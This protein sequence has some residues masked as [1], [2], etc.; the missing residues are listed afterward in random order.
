MFEQLSLFETEEERYN[1]I[2]KEIERIE[3]EREDISNKISNTFQLSIPFEG[4]NYEDD[5]DII[6][7]ESD[8]AK[9]KIAKR[10]V[11]DKIK[12]EISFLQDLESSVSSLINDD[13]NESMLYQLKSSIENIKKDIDRAKNSMEYIEST[14][15]VSSESFHK[16][17][18][19]TDYLQEEDLDSFVYGSDAVAILNDIA[20][21]LSSSDTNVDKVFLDL[22]DPN[23][24]KSWTVALTCALKGHWN[25]KDCTEIIFDASKNIE[26][27][28]K[29]IYKRYLEFMDRIL[30]Y[31]EGKL[32][33]NLSKNNSRIEYLSELK[34]AKEEYKK[35][36][37][38]L[39]SYI[40]Y[41][42][43][44]LRKIQAIVTSGAYF[45]NKSNSLDGDYSRNAFLDIGEYIYSYKITDSVGVIS[46][47]LIS[48]N[49]YFK[50]LLSTIEK[51]GENYIQT[52]SEAVLYG[53]S[54]L[55][56]PLLVEFPNRFGNEKFSKAINNIKNL[57]NVSYLNRG[58][59][60]RDEN[61][62]F[63]NAQ[64]SS[65]DS[66]IISIGRNPFD[67][68]SFYYDESPY[69][70]LARWDVIDTSI[71]NALQ[72]RNSK[73]EV[74]K[75]I[76]GVLEI[77][78][79][80]R[81]SAQKLI[82]NAKNLE[83]EVSKNILDEIRRNI[84]N[85][86][87]DDLDKLF[88]ENDF[89]TR[90]FYSPDDY[91]QEKDPVELIIFRNKEIKFI[92]YEQFLKEHF[93]KIISSCRNGIKRIKS[94]KD[95]LEND[96]EINSDE[97]AWD[98]KSLFGEF[99]DQKDRNISNNYH[100]VLKD[101]IDSYISEKSIRSDD[102][103][104]NSSVFSNIG[105][106]F[107][108][109][110][111][112]IRQRASDYSVD[113]SS[114]GVQKILQHLSN[115]FNEDDFST[116]RIMRS[117]LVKNI[118]LYSRQ[119]I[120]PDS[121][122]DDQLSFNIKANQIF[123]I[124]FGLG[125]N[126]T[127]FSELELYAELILPIINSDS[128]DFVGISEKMK[129]FLVSLSKNEVP[130]GASE[131]ENL[132]KANSTNR[133]KCIIATSFIADVVDLDIS[134]AADIILAKENYQSILFELHILNEVNFKA[135]GKLANCFK[136]NSKKLKKDDF[137]ELIFII[138]EFL[139]E[140]L[141][142]RED[143]NR[144]CSLFIMIAS[145]HYTDG[146]K[147]SASKRDAV[148]TMLEAKEISRSIMAKFSTKN[149]EVD[150]FS[151]DFINEMSELGINLGDPEEVSKNIKD[152]FKAF[153]LSKDIFTDSS[154][155][156]SGIADLK[157]KLSEF[158]LFSSLLSISEGSKKYLRESK[159]IPKNEKINLLNFEL[160]GGNFRFRVM[161]KNDKN[162]PRAGI[163][164]SCCQFIGGAGS[165]CVYDA[166][167]NSESSILVLEM[168]PNV[169]LESLK[170]KTK[171][172]SGA[173]ISSCEDGWILISQS[174]FHIVDKK[175]EIKVNN[176]G[177]EH[178]RI[179][180]LDNIESAFVNISFISD[181]CNTTYENLYVQLSEHVKENGFGPIICGKSFTRFITGA[182]DGK[183]DVD[184]RS[185][186]YKQ[187]TGVKPYTDFSP[188][189][190]YVFDKKEIEKEARIMAIDKMF[191]LIKNSNRSLV[192]LE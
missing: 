100:D 24:E 136:Y 13:L 23:L 186:Y 1:R 40:F 22:S 46:D 125:D 156:V 148:K 65:I 177:K 81:N 87:K 117:S 27:S 58:K 191:G 181:I 184:P 107:I 111:D 84:D 73:E 44:H 37:S 114:S 154:V 130:D 69:Y 31:D 141:F 15:D 192:C 83:K 20:T 170:L 174:Y 60:V 63:E 90:T 53:E 183:M 129:R 97:N 164:T 138:C 67:N 17:L 82:G 25:S 96:Y 115:K 9:K 173:Q 18:G 143:I 147:K 94:F 14:I 85:A 132:L 106:G 77:L 54:S 19:K 70:N 105:S 26:Y 32:K 34:N 122:S 139:H 142:D 16:D 68:R 55:L 56:S 86:S 72:G 39:N 10:S 151:L 29:L 2:L 167:G 134:K 119:I 149:I 150:K 21:K 50:K 52:P 146:L 12:K 45:I 93:V 153:N 124:K 95:F 190:F 155:G 75:S 137:A 185:F 78:T 113:I 165:S 80:I 11:I 28:Q 162:I 103:T 71:V 140:N 109:Q 47:Y 110:Q 76:D 42:L 61:A 51:I 168:S 152:T 179:F 126:A 176:I 41:N 187:Q 35:W 112:C 159:D 79:C 160:C 178:D 57:L 175:V 135:N 36:I 33:S 6:G 104:F 92:G 49:D 133:K 7:G 182:T 101:L 5:F 116:E 98:E 169:D 48:L 189:G 99:I 59:I 30:K 66:A 102:G 43:R 127:K 171:L 38:S 74:L 166:M 180:I 91:R 172:R 118:K 161:E 120:L 89:F 163:L 158:K 145:S 123:D 108:S 157:N 4:I 144:L 64:P 121:T 62:I 3:K 131:L 88:G 8:L 188:K 128:K